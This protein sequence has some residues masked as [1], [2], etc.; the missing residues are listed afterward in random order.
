[1]ISK[2]LGRFF[3]SA[4]TNVLLR[5]VL[6][7]AM[8]VS[9][10]SGSVS[11][12]TRAQ[13]AEPLK[14]VASFSILGDMV[15]EI[16][17]E[18]IALS[19]IV[20]PNGDAHS[21]E[22]APKDAKALAQAQVLVINGLDFEGWLPRLIQASGFKGVQVLASDGVKPRHLDESEI[23]AVASPGDHD[24]VQ[25]GAERKQASHAHGPADAGH[26]THEHRSGDV[27]PHAWQ[28][29]RNGMLYAKNIADGLGRADPHNKSY[30]QKRADAYIAQMEKLDSEVRLAL[31]AI[32]ASRRK[33]ITSHD[34][35]GYFGQAYGVQFISAVGLSSDAEPSAKDVAA[36]IDR[37]KSEGISAIFVENTSNSRLVEQI[38]RETGVT[39]GDTLYSDALALPD[40]P[41]GTYLGMFS[42]N[43]GQL[44][45]ALKGE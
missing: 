35:F 18:H 1:M 42:W 3:R 8:I 22:P 19:T 30:Y 26:Q 34:A 13:P 37:A 45:Y 21:F 5:S 39:P 14:V 33:V 28:D 9:A 36:I 44:I 38:A 29:L 10:A 15:R 23:L 7:A 31:D 24:R 17:G 25:A 41:A 16:G 4:S 40:K 2:R 32:P 20:G 12:A 43:A 6:C 27:D 11:A